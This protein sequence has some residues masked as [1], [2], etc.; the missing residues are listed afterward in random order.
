ML[1]DETSQ[2]LAQLSDLEMQY[3]I[4][5]DSKVSKNKEMSIVKEEYINKQKSINDF[6]Q[7]ITEN[8]VL[9]EKEKNKLEYKKKVC[10][11]L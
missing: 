10:K 8:T 1:E 5:F 4:L 9:L 2:K 6:K 3:N 11:E 7:L